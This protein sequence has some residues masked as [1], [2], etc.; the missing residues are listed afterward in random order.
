MVRGGYMEVGTKANPYSS[1]LTIT[2]HGSRHDAYL[3]L[4]GNKVIAIRHGELSMHGV[5]RTPVWTRLAS[6]AY[7][8]STE[9]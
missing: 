3:P 4:Y 9:L 5:P 8:G 7:A 2:L 1:K 6:T